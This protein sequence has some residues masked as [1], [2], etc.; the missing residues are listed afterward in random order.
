MLPVIK[1]LIF[2]EQ[3]F[4]RLRDANENVVLLNNLIRFDV[5][6]VRWF[7][8]NRVKMTRDIFCRGGITVQ[9]DKKQTRTSWS[10]PVEGNG[11]CKLRDKEK[12]NVTG[13][14]RLDTPPAWSES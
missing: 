9:R 10:L 13:P 6:F 4:Q 8:E 7:P 3:N 2:T 5:K 1:V 12:K 14:R 11:S